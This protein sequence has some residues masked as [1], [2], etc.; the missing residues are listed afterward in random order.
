MGVVVE[1]QADKAAWAEG[2]ARRMQ[3]EA[4]RAQNKMW[5]CQKMMLKRQIGIQMKRTLHIVLKDL[6]FLGRHL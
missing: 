6:Q 2:G 3:V 4:A 5:E 1:F